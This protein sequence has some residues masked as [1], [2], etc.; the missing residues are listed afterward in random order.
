MYPQSMFGA[1]IRTIS[2]FFALK[3]FIFY[4]FKN[5]YILHGHVFIMN[6]LELSAPRIKTRPLSVNPPYTCS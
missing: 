6:V 4:N 1:K 2:K 3:I 5:F